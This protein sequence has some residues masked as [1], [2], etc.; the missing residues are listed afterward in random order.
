MRKKY[1]RTRAE[2][3]RLM[4]REERLRE[5]PRFEMPWRIRRSAVKEEELRQDPWWW[6]GHRRGMRRPKVGQDPLEARAVPEEK[7]YGSL[8]ERIMWMRLTQLH[9]YFDFQSSLQGGRLELG[10]LVAD[11]ILPDHMYVI[12]VQGPTHQGPY[13]HFKDE[14]QRRILEE[15]GYTVFDIDDKTIYDEYA[16][17][18]WIRRLFGFGGFG[19]YAGGATTNLDAFQEAD[20]RIPEQIA[21]DLRAIEEM[22]R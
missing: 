17:E 1:G 8:P 14:E 12:R 9:V 19:G 18:E 7:I 11:F 15:M 3:Q 21:D 2:S 16:F 4:S 5:P 20:D 13:R 22:L 10:G 6:I